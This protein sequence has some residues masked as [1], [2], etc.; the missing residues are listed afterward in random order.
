MIYKARN[1]APLISRFTSVGTGEIV[2]GEIQLS[3]QVFVT[4]NLLK[5]KNIEVLLEN[6]LKSSIVDLF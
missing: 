4:T 1:L 2:H 3:E 6:Y 5:I